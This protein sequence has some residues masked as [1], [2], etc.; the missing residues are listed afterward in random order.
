MREGGKVRG[1]EEGCRGK[2][3]KRGGK[4]REEGWRKGV[5]KKREGR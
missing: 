4:R 3:I 1:R 5:G 2:K